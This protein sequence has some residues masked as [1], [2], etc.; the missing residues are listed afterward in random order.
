MFV[1]NLT[2]EQMERLRKARQ[3]L[4]YG[5]LETWQELFIYQLSI[6]NYTQVK[7]IGKFAERKRKKENI[8]LP[9]KDFKNALN[10][11]L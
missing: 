10:S 8:T 3:I 7:E 4:K 9:L 5:H 6:G 2:E 11:S 1:G